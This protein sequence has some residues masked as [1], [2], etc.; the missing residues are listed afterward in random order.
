ML[1]SKVLL[2]HFFL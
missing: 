2:Y 1:S